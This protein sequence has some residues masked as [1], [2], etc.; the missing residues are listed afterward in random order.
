MTVLNKAIRRRAEL[1]P[2]LGPKEAGAVTVT[3][4][5]NGDIGFRKLRRREEVRVTLSAVYSL[6]LKAEAKVRALKK[7][8]VQ[9]VFGKQRQVR[10]KR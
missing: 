10:R 7:A 2:K 9:L 1:D 4:Y 5:P 3:L 8:H 6:A